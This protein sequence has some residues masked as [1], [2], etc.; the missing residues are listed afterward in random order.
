MQIRN[1]GIF[2]KRL[3]ENTMIYL[4]GSIGYSG[5]EI[6]WRGFTHWT[7]AVTG[8]ICFLLLYRLNFRCLRDHW[9][10]KCLKGSAIITGVEFIVGCIVNRQLHWN[11]WDYSDSFGNVL[12]QV[13]PL[14]S[15]LWFF[16]CIPVFKLATS[17]KRKF[18]LHNLRRA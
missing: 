10:V 11:V 2:M 5:I 8:G 18:F 1:G 3:K 17:L 16:L 6:L 4:I 14:Y 12:G 15:I 7:M 9:A 13:C